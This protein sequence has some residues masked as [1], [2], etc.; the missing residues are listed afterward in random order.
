[1][2]KMGRFSPDDSFVDLSATSRNLD[3][4][5][6][7]DVG[8][9]ILSQTCADMYRR[10]VGNGKTSMRSWPPPLLVRSTPH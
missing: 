4:S 1:M 2:G 8:D 7:A 5:T 6:L 3:T 10:K 9:Q